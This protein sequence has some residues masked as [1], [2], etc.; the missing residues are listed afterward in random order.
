MTPYGIT[1]LMD[2]KTSVRDRADILVKNIKVDVKN[3][4]HSLMD[5][6]TSARDREWF[7]SIY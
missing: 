3:R 1:S 7:G 5:E 2:E 4:I 6:K